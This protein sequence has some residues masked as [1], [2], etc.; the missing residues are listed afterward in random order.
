[1]NEGAI[2]AIVVRCECGK[3]FQTR[4]ENAG[5]RARCPICQRELIVPEP[6]PLPDG[7]FAPLHD[8]GP[9]KTSGKAIASLALGISSLLCSILAGVPAIIFG[10]LGLADINNPRKRVSGKGLAISGIVL[11]SVTSFMM[12]IL[13][14]VLIAL[15]LPAVQAA[16]EAARRAQC[17]N[18]L[19]QIALAMFNYQS[20]YACFP[21]A[22]TYDGQGK[23]LL[24]WRV[25]ILPYLNEGTLYGQFHLDEPWD[26]PH[27]KLLGGQMP[28]VFRCPSELETH[29]LTTYQVV[30]DPRSMFTG[31]P[32]GVAINTVTDG[33]SNTLLVAESTSPVLWSKPS[34]NSLKSSDPLLGMGSKHPGGFNATMADG[35]VRFFKTS[36]SSQ[37]LKALVTRNG[38]EPVDVP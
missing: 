23:P 1:M 29:E 3:E 2:V 17:T 34:D 10:I 13:V 37:V 24:S 14:P 4:D 27:N 19:K 38:D 15:L 33:T 36:I 20:T 11:G 7:D 12:C 5:R 18:N 30:V 22:A 16:R 26:S 9:P 25:L 32:S 6:K 21:P 8:F 35:S 31:K 28:N